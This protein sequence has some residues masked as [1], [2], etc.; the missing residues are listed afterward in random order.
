MIAF[1]AAMTATVLIGIFFYFKGRTGTFF[2]ILSVTAL[3]IST[4]SLISFISPY[5]Y[6]LPTHHCPFCVLQKEYSYAGYLHYIFLMGGVVCGAG[7][8]LLMPFRKIPSLKDI[9]PAVQKRLAL[10]SVVL[11]F[12]FT[13]LVTVQIVFSNLRMEG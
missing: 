13:V 10:V 11:Y 3:F 6:E 12:L 4:A 8:G 5:I 7:T 9:I 2:A 1:Y